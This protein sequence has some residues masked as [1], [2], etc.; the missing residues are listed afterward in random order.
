MLNQTF[1]ITLLPTT[2]RNA[3]Q[4]PPELLSLDDK[5]SGVAIR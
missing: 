3:V 2:A 4:A 5:Y 1:L